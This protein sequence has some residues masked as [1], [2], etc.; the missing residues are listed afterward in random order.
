MGWLQKLIETYDLCAG[1]T[2]FETN[3]LPSISHTP[4]QT[5]IEIIIDEFGVFRRAHIVE[6]EE[7]LV[8]ATEESAGR[9]GTKPPPHP[10][11]DKIQYVAADYPAYGGTKPSF[12]AEYLEQL[13]AW[14]ESPF[15]HRKAQAVLNYVRRG[16]VVND[17]IKQ[18]L[19]Y[20]GNDGILLTKW[21]AGGPKPDIFRLLP[22]GNAD[23]G[24]A[25]IRWQVEIPGDLA[26]AVTYRRVVNG[27]AQM[28]A[29]DP[30]LQSAWVRFNA[31][32]MQQKGLCMASG[33]AGVAL[34][35]SH[36]KRLRHPGD[37]TKLIS[38][39][40]KSGFTFRG[41]FTDASGDQ[42][43]TI[44]YEA[45]QKAHLALR[46]LIGR[47]AYRNGD[48]VVVSWS[49]GGQDIPDPLADPFTLFGISEASTET[50]YE[51]DAGQAYALA[52]KLKIAGYRSCLPPLASIIVMALDSATPGRLSIAFYREFGGGEFL[53]RIE[54]WHTQFAWHQNFGKDRKFI[55]APAPRDI[56]EA[57]YGPGVDDRLRKACVERLL[58]CVVDGQPI[59]RDLVDQTYRRA[60]RR[61]GLAVWEW[62][63]TLGVACALF[64]GYQHQLKQGN[65]AMALEPDRNSRDYLFGRL[66]SYADHIEQRA[67]RLAG[68][69]RDT[70]AA[71]LMQ[72]F[73]DHPSS[74]WR[75]I[76]GQLGPSRSRLRSRSPGYLYLLEQQL[77]QIF[78]QFQ[79]D[80]FTN[81][82][83]LT[84]E[85]L[86]GYHCQRAKLNAPKPVAPSPENPALS[87]SE[88][89][90]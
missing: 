82:R 14:C 56:A 13:T 26:S 12:H 58:P 38:A 66:L 27:K 6:K 54:A 70:N 65:F 21:P 68:E 39:N 3:P 84:A 81:D 60:T 11:C 29:G 85:F 73:A 35:A 16:T 47:Q 45:S 75:Q 67:L 7:A 55:G 15:T 74:T 49:A 19:L 34:A 61:M 79:G 78:E 50:A 71:K 53:G 72:R 76:N 32:R 23:Q 22:A 5:H 48:Q 33:E 1:A 64:R 17:L 8:P 31:S 83:K 43:C 40:D 4:Q 69:Q 52:L 41:R 18:Q 42:A 25:F 37:G 20:L 2:Q 86:L 87:D 44:G 63:R 28:V 57:A 46:W 36:P 77:D 9:V 90:S 59:P 62:E 30:D 10:F 51:G 80:D 88:K 24:N 89:T